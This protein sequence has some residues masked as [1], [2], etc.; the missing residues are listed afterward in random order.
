[1]TC[2]GFLKRKHC[3]TVLLSFPYLEYSPSFI[4]RSECLLLS[5]TFYVLWKELSSIPQISISWRKEY[6]FSPVPLQKS[7]SPCRAS[8]WRSVRSSHL[9]RRK[10]NCGRTRSMKSG[11]LLVW[12]SPEVRCWRWWCLYWRAVRRVNRR[13]GERRPE[14]CDLGENPKLTVSRKYQ[15]ILIPVVK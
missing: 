6:S 14:R 11:R 5:D 3:S 4:L 15:P 12:V 13:E 1:M 2:L 9:R 7:I 10:P 8:S